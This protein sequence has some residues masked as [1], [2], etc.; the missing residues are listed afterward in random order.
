MEAVAVVAHAVKRMLD[1]RNSSLLALLMLHNNPQ[2]AGKKVELFTQ[3]I[4]KVSQVG[5]M[6]AALAS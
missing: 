5:K 4:L 2:G 3:T 1:C 6:Q